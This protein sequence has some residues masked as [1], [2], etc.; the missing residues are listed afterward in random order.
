MGCGASSLKGDDVPAVNSQPVPASQQLKKVRTDFSS[1]DYDQDARRR[2][3]TEYAPHET[4]APIREQSY[5]MSAEQQESFAYSQQAQFQTDDGA[6]GQLD[7][8]AGAST[9]Y[10]RGSTG[11]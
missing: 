8:N 7:P 4:P 6:P 11:P 2:R 3:L 5:D 10:P 9:G 1:V